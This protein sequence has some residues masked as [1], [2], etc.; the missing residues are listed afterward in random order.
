MSYP[1]EYEAAWAQVLIVL[2]PMIERLEKDPTDHIG[3]KTHLQAAERW[4]PVILGGNSETTFWEVLRDMATTSYWKA[5]NDSLEHRD[6][7]TTLIKAEQLLKF[8]RHYASLLGLLGPDA[9][10]VLESEED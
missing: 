4:F 2:K 6:M 9:T 8:L 1:T 5:I 3:C 7:S 10:E